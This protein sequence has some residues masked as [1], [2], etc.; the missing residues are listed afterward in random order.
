MITVTKSKSIPTET[1]RVSTSIFCLTLFRY[2][3]HNRFV[4]KINLP[5]ISTYNALFQKLSKRMKEKCFVKYGFTAIKRWMDH[6]RNYFLSSFHR[7]IAFNKNFL[8]FEI[9]ICNLWIFQYCESWIEICLLC[10]PT[11]DYTFSQNPR[12]A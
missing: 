9:G 7:R 10:L 3:N 8:V 11:T 6:K 4:A 1:W 12:C 5:S 2:C